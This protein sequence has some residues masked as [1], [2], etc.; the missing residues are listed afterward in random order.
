MLEITHR[1]AL[2]VGADSLDLSELARLL[3]ALEACLL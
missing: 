2:R 1:I 3:A